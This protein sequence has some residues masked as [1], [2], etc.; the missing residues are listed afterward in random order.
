MSDVVDLIEHDHREVE[1]MFAQFKK[2][3]DRD[4][5]IAICDELDKHTR[6]EESAVYPVFA[7]ELSDEEGKVKEA[8]DEHKEARQLIGQIRNT[9]DQEH[10]SELMA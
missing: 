4:R 3:H 2:S 8:S 1:G 7:E 10:L 5:A 9:Q 6:A